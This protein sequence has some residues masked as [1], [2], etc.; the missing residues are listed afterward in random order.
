MKKLSNL[1]I[2]TI[3][4]T[5]SII[6]MEQ[7]PEGYLRQTE[8]SYKNL[9]NKIEYLNKIR[10][11]EILKTKQKLKC[12]RIKGLLIAQ[13]EEDNMVKVEIINRKNSKRLLKI[14][15][16]EKYWAEELHCYQNNTNFLCVFVSTKLHHGNMLTKIILIDLN[17]NKIVQKIKNV[18]NFD[19]GQNYITFHNSCSPIVIQDLKN[20][21][22][23]PLEFKPFSKCKSFGNGEFFYVKHF[24]DKPKIVSPKK[25]RGEDEFY[26]SKKSK[27]SSL[28]F[29]T[30]T[31]NKSLGKKIRFVGKF[32][33]VIKN[34]GR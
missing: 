21:K 9:I 29:T 24:G 10:V 18:Q 19:L 16:H 23:V 22:E 26:F 8:K 17:T 7:T 5:S 27:A 15:N 6:G 33:S 31:K 12:E 4:T 13:Y 34:K 14:E 28:V 11:T 25:K 2:A 1:I 3:I 32:Y 20:T 30:P